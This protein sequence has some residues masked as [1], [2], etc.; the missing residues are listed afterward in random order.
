MSPVRSEVNR[1]TVFNSN[2]VDTKETTCFWSTSGS[3]G[4]YSSFGSTLYLIKLASSNWD[5][6]GD[7]RRYPSKDRADYQTL[8][9]EQKHIFTSNLKYR[10]I[11]IL[12][13][14]GVLA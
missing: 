9:E 3:S 5:I 13:K 10:H 6:S 2:K 14:G 1:M 8:S 4:K 7:L 12:Y 11:W